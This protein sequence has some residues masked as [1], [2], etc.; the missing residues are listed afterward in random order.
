MAR[1]LSS[2]F[3]LVAAG[4]STDAVA[5][6]TNPQMRT[7]AIRAGRRRGAV[8]IPCIAPA[9]GAIGISEN[10]RC[11]DFTLTITRP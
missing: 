8:R 10:S 11:I 2:L 7:M 9:P 1:R 4:A 5:G 6:L 3:R